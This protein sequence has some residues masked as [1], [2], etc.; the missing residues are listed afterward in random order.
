MLLNAM[1]TCTQHVN[2]KIS[3]LTFEF[4]IEFK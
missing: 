4:W 3:Y 1:L 2:K